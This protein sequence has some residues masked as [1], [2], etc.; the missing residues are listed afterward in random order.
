ME[1][2]GQEVY[3]KQPRIVDVMLPHLSR[4]GTVIQAGAHVGVWPDRLC[5]EFDRVVSFE[6]APDSWLV[7]RKI[8][9]SPNVMVINGALGKERG[10]TA[11]GQGMKPFDGSRKVVDP[12][13]GYPVASYTIDDLPVWIRNDV[14]AIVLD[15]EGYELEALA[16]AEL[17]IARRRPLLVLEDGQKLRDGLFDLLKVEYEIVAEAHRDIILKA[18]PPK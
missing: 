5:T 17:T 6:P 2:D 15:I 7:S 9:T 13:I 14:D 10:I 18:K 1:I 3:T 8:A 4:K 16:G 12:S 11:V